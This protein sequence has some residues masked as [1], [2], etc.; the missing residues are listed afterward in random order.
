MIININEAQILKN[1]KITIT[2]ELT[3]KFNPNADNKITL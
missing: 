3:F 1:P 2:T